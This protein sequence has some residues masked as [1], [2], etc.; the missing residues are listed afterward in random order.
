MSRYQAFF[1]D[2]RH[3]LGYVRVSDAFPHGET[4]IEVFDMDHNML[5]QTDTIEGV[6]AIYS[7]TPSKTVR[8][9]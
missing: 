1:D 8:D 5:G 9:E 4:T 3:Q 6:K 2:K 7:P